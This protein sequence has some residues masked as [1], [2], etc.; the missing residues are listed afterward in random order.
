MSNE[1]F[2]DLGD[3][4]GASTTYPILPMA[5]YEMR[6]IS[7]EVV[8]KKDDSSKKNLLVILGT[9]NAHK[10]VNGN[11]TNMGLQ[12]RQ[13][14]GLAETEKRKTANIQSDLAKLMMCFLGHQTGK[15]DPDQ[16]VDKTGSVKLKIENS[17][18]YG[19][20]NAVATYIPKK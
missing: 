17:E 11:D 20:K 12:V 18:E 10:D 13:Y 15:F 4:S 9:T 1:I 2:D 19:D 3:L 8:D 6:V 16:L 14:I 5:V 7:A